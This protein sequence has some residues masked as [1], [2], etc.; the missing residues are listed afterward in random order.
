MR[1][2][3]IFPLVVVGF[4]SKL[5]Q[6]TRV[7]FRIVQERIQA[8]DS[9]IRAPARTKVSGDRY[10]RIA[11]HAN[12]ISRSGLLFRKRW[13]GYVRDQDVPSSARV[14]NALYQHYFSLDLL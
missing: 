6:R 9:S 5:C 4:R 13:H 11:P 10:T 12:E 7:I 8:L 3:V 14:A 2:N 1:T